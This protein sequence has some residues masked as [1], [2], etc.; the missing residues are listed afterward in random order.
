MYKVFINEKKLS[1]C[2]SPQDIDKNLHFEGLHTLEIAI[3]ALENTSATEINVYGDDVE[4]IWKT[5]KSIFKIVE[6]AGGIVSNTEKKVLFIYRL[7]K[8]DLP[9]GRIEEGE[10]I[11]D[12]AVREVAEET[13]ISNINLEHFIATTYHVYRERNGVK[14]LKHVHWY[15]M[16]Y[17]GNEIPVPQIEE[18]ITDVQ[19]LNEEEI[20]S[21]V[22]PNTFKNIRLILEEVG[23]K[24]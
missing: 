3:D 12:T 13:L 16:S 9:K 19:W 22:Y 6:A 1:L 23:F 21:K 4:M 15:K 17:D 10:S 8:W 20:F 18:G 2:N 24:N 7:S 11:E 14:V 5:F